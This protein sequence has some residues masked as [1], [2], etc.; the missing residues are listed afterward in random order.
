ML[1]YSRP[2]KRGTRTVTQA[3]RIGPFEL[4]ECLG[5]G[6]GTRLYRAIRPHGAR[7]PYE[8]C[9]RIA[10]NP[11]D[12]VV[13]AAIRAEYETLRAMDNPRVPRA[14]GHYAD[15]SALAMSYYAG[16]SLADA[17]QARNDGLVNITISSALDFAIEIAHGFR[18][19][20]SMTGP[21]NQKIVHGHL[22]PQRIRI[23]PAGELVLVGFGCVPRGRHPA[24][25]APEVANGSAATPRSDQWTLGSI[26]VEMI[27][28]ERLYAAAANVEEA[29]RE[30]DVAYWVQQAAEQHPELGGPLRTMLAAD[31]AQRF[32]ENHQLLKAL[33]AAGRKIGGTVNRRSFATAVMAHGNRLSRV[34]PERAS[35]DS[36]STTTEVF[37]APTPTFGRYTPPEPQLHTDP[38]QPAHPW[39]QP[40]MQ[41]LPEPSATPPAP[42]LAP[43]YL[44]SE[45]AGTVLG[46]IMMVLGAVYVFMVL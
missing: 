15:E 27:V 43:R 8:V 24:Y 22:G 42:T 18:H 16:A 31:P 30:G 23:T 37:V 6:A 3:R 35:L 12:P 38:M 28:G 17:I 46:G 44:P 5:E 9:I 45:V 10:T 2:D 20:P 13:A 11:L 4:A 14:F 34:R 19:A 33:L 36:A 39:E 7:P 40:T 29:V 32:A 25:T 21:G 26:L 41:P 1:R